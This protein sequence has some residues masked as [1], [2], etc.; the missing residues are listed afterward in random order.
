MSMASQLRIVTQWFPPE[1]PAFG[2]M[3]HELGAYLVER[4]WDVEVYTTLPSHPRG[5]VF[6]GFESRRSRTEEKDGMK[7]RRLWSWI[8][9]S[10]SIFSRG[11]GFLSYSCSVLF[12]TL[13]SRNKPDVILAPL[14]PLFLGPL[15]GLACRF[16]GIPLVFIVQDLHPD[17]LVDLGLVRNRLVIRAL[18]WC[19]RMGYRSA[20]K[21]ITI[22]SSFAEQIIQRDGGDGDR[23]VVISNWAGDDVLQY[24]ADGQAFRAS[25]KLKPDGALA[26]FAGTLS[27]SSGASILPAVAAILRERS[28]E[29]QLVVVGE[30][31]LRK[32]LDAAVAGMDDEQLVVMDFQPREDVADMLAAADLTVVTVDDRTAKNSLPSKVL[33]YLAAARPVVAACDP[34]CPLGRMLA[35]SGAA[36][37][38]PPGDAPRLAEAIEDL[39]NDPSRC[40]RYALAAR[41]YVLEH[42]SGSVCLDRYERV[43]QGCISQG[44]DH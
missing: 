41:Q 18:S 6:D 24:Q 29:V 19:E 20:R 5:V 38:V 28:S 16:R 10:R 44:S 15:L 12:A 1:Q 30:G 32:D 37:L 31:P 21:I 22:C 2:I 39:A 25:R 7:V 3:M 17:A 27:Y 11:M 35:D 9:P 13:F 43:L 42:A 23:C 33:S 8:S 14:Q 36:L 26:M 4:G 34:E 40:E